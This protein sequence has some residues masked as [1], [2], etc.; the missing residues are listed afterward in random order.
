M[1]RRPCSTSVCRSLALW[2]EYAARLGTR[3]HTSGTLLVGRDQ[4]DLQQVERQCSLLRGRGVE[5]AMLDR[6][7]AAPS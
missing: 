1:A 2:P 7:R 5:V 3:L 6:R 4:G